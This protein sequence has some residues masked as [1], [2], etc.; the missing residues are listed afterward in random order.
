MRVLRVARYH[1][2]VHRDHVVQGLDET[3]LYHGHQRRGLEHGTRLCGESD[4]HVVDFVQAAV[5][6][7]LGEV[8]HRAD[9]TGLHV[10]DHGAPLVDLRVGRHLLP[11]RLVN[12]VLKSDVQGGPDIEAVF[13]LDV[14]AVVV[15]D[16]LPVVGRTEPDLSLF[17]VKGVVIF[18][19]KAYVIVA[20]G[21]AVVF[22][23]PYRASCQGP[24]RVLPGIPLVDN[25]SALV[26]SL[27]HQ[28]QFLQPQKG[29]PVKVGGQ[30]HVPVAV[31]APCDDH[32]VVVSGAASDFLRQSVAESLRL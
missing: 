4:R 9:R 28:R 7:I 29:S 27:L 13:R 30:S 5:L 17:A 22:H 32:P 15:L 24:V 19:L 14:G 25:D 26:A 3:V 10:H 12:D 1:T 31:L 6:G 8:H 21:V 20:V 2:V 23:V 18:P 11:H 16:P